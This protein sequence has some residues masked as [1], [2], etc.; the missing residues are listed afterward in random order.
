MEDELW[1]S[2]YQLLLQESKHR[3]RRK[4]VWFTDLMI[5]GVFFWAVL[6]DRPVSW[7]CRRKSW[8]AQMPWDSLP[9]A[10]AMSRRLRSF[11]VI[12]L[13]KAMLDALAATTTPSL[14]HSVDAKPLVVGGF[15][16]DHDAKWGY[17]VD[18]KAR[19]YKLFAIWSE[20]SP[21]P[22]CWDLGPM[23]RSEPVVAEQLV[24]RLDRGG[25]LLGD[26]A[27]DTNPLH[28]LCAD[29]GLQ[30]VAPR[31][32]PGT[33]LG[34]TEHSHS[35]LRSIELLEVR[36]AIL[37][38][39]SRTFGPDLFACRTSIE[40]NFGNL[41]NFG[42]GL[43]PLPNWVRRPHRVAMWVAAKLAINGLRILKNKGV[44][45]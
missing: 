3:L 44:T 1:R 42:G 11:S 32:K 40:R 9:S 4:G 38:N 24:G 30:L 12:S 10:S 5:L 14:L 21:V 20:T 34:H 18:G 28:Q 29:H 19:G 13:L 43:A 15:S 17:A 8:P 41:G 31:K 45:A 33:G 16:K 6:H 25:Y 23:N 35:R 22:D 37:G 7:A 39:E 27:Y 26:S 36:P 2:L